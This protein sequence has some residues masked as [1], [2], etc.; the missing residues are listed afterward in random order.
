MKTLILFPGIVLGK[1]LNFGDLVIGLC[2]L[3][4]STSDPKNDPNTAIYW[5]GLTG[6]LGYWLTSPNRDD[7]EKQKSNLI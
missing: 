7:K 4:L 5:G 1:T 3:K 6:V 2:I